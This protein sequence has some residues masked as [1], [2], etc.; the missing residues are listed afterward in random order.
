MPSFSDPLPATP[1]HP[2][3][4]V[5]RQRAIE[6][7][8]GVTLALNLAVAVAKIVYGHAVDALAIRADGFHSLTDA[9]NNVVG[10]VALRLANRPPDSGH[11][12]GHHKIEVVTA[13]LVGVSLLAMA[14]DV[15]RSSLASLGGSAPLPAID[16]GAF[17]VLGAT[18]AVNL[19][20]AGYERKK[21][22]ELESPFLL[23]DAL[24]TRS[25]VL[26]TVGVL[27][28]A[29]LVRRGFAVV[30]IVMAMLLAAFI[31]W[32]GVSVLRRNIGY[33]SDS[34]QVEPSRIEQV[35]VQVPG[36]ASAHKIR[37]RG[38][39]GAVYVDLHI[40]IAPHLDVVA[41]HRV[42]HWVIDAIK[43]EIP[44]VADVTIHTEP[45]RPGQPYPPLPDTH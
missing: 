17:V 2:A 3:A 38:A 39:P 32:T 41:A 27:A 24:H 40:Q 19:I 45:A 34:A 14:F 10:I 42:T 25:D 23:S 22:R 7:V 15:I 12:Y 33:L 21:A 29:E 18:L 11:P 20:V 8:L 1:A 6:R 36:V 43:R 44:G 4:A 26:V 30:D 5:N 35:V 13:S 31:A 16:A 37:T 9:A 28:A